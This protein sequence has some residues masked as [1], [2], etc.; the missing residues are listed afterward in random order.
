MTLKKKSLRK[1]TVP[2]L[3]GIAFFTRC[4]GQQTIQAV[5]DCK[6][7]GPD[8]YI[9]DIETFRSGSHQTEYYGGIPDLGKDPEGEWMYDGKI[10][11]RI[12]RDSREVSFQEL[13]IVHRDDLPFKPVGLSFVR[14]GRNEFL[15]VLNRFTSGM[16]VLEKYSIDRNEIKFEHRFRAPEIRKANHFIATGIDRFI[17]VSNQSSFADSVF[18]RGSEL[19]FLAK[20]RL[21]KKIE[22]SK[23]IQSL[24]MK[25]N[26]RTWGET[27]RGIELIGTFG[28]GW[29]EYT[30][31]QSGI[32]TTSKT[33][34]GLKG[35]IRT[36]TYLDESTAILAGTL[37]EVSQNY[38]GEDSDDPGIFLGI[39]QPG[40][41]FQ[42]LLN[43]GNYD[44]KV[45]SDLTFA[46]K[47]YRLSFY[48]RKG[49]QQCSLP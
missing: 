15:Y 33:V 31:T 14:D 45:L 43:K 23:K 8:L 12:F 18:G 4:S 3:L 32:S 1:L 47:D 34:N 22:T 20:D 36:V 42:I 29:K 11:R 41:N 10:Y 19:S 6:I 28:A 21:E 48:N 35:T 2:L 9:F 25:N 40:R 37:K 27:D 44:G 16:R 24:E 17:L 26:N 38:P 30:I 46:G 49:L 5:G 7:L 13:T 39:H